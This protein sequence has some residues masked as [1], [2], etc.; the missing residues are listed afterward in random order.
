MILECGCDSEKTL[1]TIC[2]PGNGKCDCKL[3]Y[4][5]EKCEKCAPM[6]Y[7]HPACFSKLFYF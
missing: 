7:G 2:A 5:G 1:D 6:F 3:G 4:D